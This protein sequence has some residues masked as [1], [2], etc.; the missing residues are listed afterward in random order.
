M[1]QTEAIEKKNILLAQLNDVTRTCYYF[2]NRSA[3]FLIDRGVLLKFF[4]DQ[5]A[6][7]DP[8]FLEE[9]KFDFDIEEI[10]EEIDDS[11]ETAKIMA[12]RLE[13]LNESIVQYLIQN[14]TNKQT[15]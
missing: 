14:A 2:P 5:R 12:T 11:L 7:F 9:T 4:S 3:R 6:N 15:K 8:S 13:E 10:K 1:G